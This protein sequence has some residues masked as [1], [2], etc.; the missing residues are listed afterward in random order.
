MPSPFAV[1]AHDSWKA[2]HGLKPPWGQREYVQLATALRRL[3][4]EA[5]AIKAWDTYLAEDDPFYDGHS[6]GQFLAALSK[7]LVRSFE[8]RSK[9]RAVDAL[10]PQERQNRSERKRFE[11]MR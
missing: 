3:P 7:F 2:R 4:D 9:L 10:S 11:T 8:D 5:T 6:P 1:H